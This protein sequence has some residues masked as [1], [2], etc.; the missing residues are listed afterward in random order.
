M[1]L[2]NATVC[3]EAV[4]RVYRPAVVLHLRQVLKKRFPDRWKKELV[5]SVGEEDWKANE[6]SVRARHVSGELRVKIVDDFD[7]LDLSHFY[8]LFDKHFC[9]IVPCKPGETEKERTRRKKAVLDWT[10]TVKTLRDPLSHPN[11]QD[12]TFQD[13]FR[14]I[15]CAFRVLDALSLPDSIQ[16]KNIIDDLSGERTGEAASPSEPLQSNLPAYESVVVDF[17]GRE[18]DR[19]ALWSWLKNPQAKRWAL[20]GEGG[21]GKSAIAYQF[22]SEVRLG[23]TDSIQAVWWLSAK[24][25]KYLDGTAVLISEPEFDGLSSAYDKLLLSYGCND[26]LQWSVD[27]RRSR[28]LQLLNDVPAMVVVDDLDSLEGED[29][30]AIEF[31][32]FAA[33]ATKSK[34]LLTT[35][36]TVF[37]IA[38][39][40]THV[41]GM[42]AD[43]FRKFLQSRAKIFGLDWRAFTDSR[44]SEVAELTERSPL[45]A[46]DL[47]R[48]AASFSLHEAIR[49]WHGKFG[50]EARQYALKRE[51]DILSSNARE[52]LLCA[53]LS[54]GPTSFAELE[55]LTGFP[56]Q[57]LQIAIAEMQKLFLVPKPRLI[58][59]EERFD[60]NLNT[61]SLVL[62]AFEATDAF[63]RAK[64]AV[65]SSGGRL[66]YAAKGQ[67]GGIIREVVFLVRTGEFLKAEDLLR[68]SLKSQPNN[69]DLT[70]AMGYLY[71]C[72]KPTRRITDA[73]QFFA[74]ASQLKCR[75]VDPYRH[76]ITLEI[77]EKEWT[78][79]IR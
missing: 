31:F 58:E 3:Y 43:D 44:I 48:L 69:P 14:M 45:Y 28:V 46:E 15:D 72:W 42:N 33:P 54:K 76:W 4:Q 63:R 71:K 65:E 73:R 20:A 18:E 61:R 79:A 2:S 9:E 59:G 29:E 77:D 51:L 19:K 41:S 38:H 24:K 27:E 35:R 21:K 68:A 6:E 49:G 8:N 10:Q 32:T 13:T 25:R 62:K 22:A 40:T 7:L 23:A 12:F 60:V 34:V 5:V 66:P 67:T 78:N 47:L 1:K 37:G 57:R 75:R 74:R 26:F 70:G 30:A 17:I 39:T 52:A 50:D 64:A 55:A 36:R 56:K 53:C 16:L 11:D